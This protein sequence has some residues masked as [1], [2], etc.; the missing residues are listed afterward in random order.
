MIRYKNFWN[1]K[2]LLS[3]KFPAHVFCSNKD[4]I[5]QVGN[6][7]ELCII[8]DKCI[9]VPL[10]TALM[11]TRSLIHELT[12]V[13][14][15]W[16][17]GR[18]HFSFLVKNIQPL[19][20]QSQPDQIWDTLWMLNRFLHKTVRINGELYHLASFNK[21]IDFVLPHFG[22]SLTNGPTNVPKPK[23]SHHLDTFTFAKTILESIVAFAFV[24]TYFLRR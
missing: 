20:K 9:M 11:W 18:A 6:K 16:H 14:I 19:K 13:E 17:T 23:D 3:V 1:F 2:H 8:K 24:P 21:K 12:P 15:C 10:W 4:K 22:T 5:F 7:L